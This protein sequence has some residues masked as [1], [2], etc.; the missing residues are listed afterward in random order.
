MLIDVDV[1]RDTDTAEPVVA[2]PSDRQT[3]RPHLGA[4]EGAGGTRHTTGSH[5]TAARARRPRTVV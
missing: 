3:V 2:R 4:A 5:S 1:F